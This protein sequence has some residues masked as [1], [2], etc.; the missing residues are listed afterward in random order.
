MHYVESSEMK[1]N[2]KLYTGMEKPISRSWIL[3]DE[4]LYNYFGKLDRNLRIVELGC[5][6][7]YFLGKLREMGFKNL[8]GVDIGNYLKEQTF[9]HHIADLNVDKLPFADGSVDVVVAFQ[10]MEH[11]ENY[12]L[13]VQEV[14]R[15]L[16]TGGLF[17][18]SVPNQF[19]IFFRFKFAFTGNMPPWSLGNNHL[20]FITRDVFKKTFLKDFD[21]VRTRFEKGMV[22]LLGRLNII[23]GVRFRARTRVLPR[24]ESLA[25]KACYFLRKK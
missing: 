4:L 2:P 14:K 22:P 7:G 5:G 16:R 9:E 3:R 20:L 19:N 18:F 6:Q 23:P 1:K 11:L 17:V 8:A 24:W 13:V 21:L 10:M 25:D 12:F 15:I